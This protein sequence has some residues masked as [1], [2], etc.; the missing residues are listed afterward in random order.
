M[1]SYIYLLREREFLRLNENVYK[2]GKTEQEPNSRLAGYPK[3]SEIILFINTIDCHTTEAKILDIFKNIFVQRI[4]IGVEYF[5]GDKNYM[6][7]IIC[8][9]INKINCSGIFR[10]T[11]NPKQNTYEINNY[12]I[13]NEKQN[14]NPEKLDSDIKNK[15]NNLIEGKSKINKELSKV[16]IIIENNLCEN[17]I[18][19][20]KNIKNNENIKYDCEYC[21]F[22]T[23]DKTIWYRHKK[24]K[25]H[26]NNEQ[27]NKHKNNTLNRLEI[28]SLKQKI[29]FLESKLNKI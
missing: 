5:E 29:E 27:R 10:Y 13:D 26:K 16:E 17:K 8:D 3:G 18:K 4:D 11:S 22:K 6:V 23:N 28:D 2:I 21:I 7:R 15:E 12:K 19:K 20:D 14:I 1:L 25:K 9:V 24:S